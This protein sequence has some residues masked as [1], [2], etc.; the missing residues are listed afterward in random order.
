MSSIAKYQRVAE[1]ARKRYT[2]NHVLVV[3]TGG[4]PSIYSRIENAAFEKYM[5]MPR[6]ANGSIIF[7]AQCA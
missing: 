1:W 5:R 7:C 2:K 4:V 3:S 6:D